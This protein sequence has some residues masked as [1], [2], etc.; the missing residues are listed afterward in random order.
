MNDLTSHARGTYQRDILTGRARISGSD[1]G[2]R[3]FRNYNGYR[4]SRGNLISRLRAAGHVVTV[5]ARPSSVTGRSMNVLIV[6]GRAV[7][8]DH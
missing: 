8:R 5:E 6:D 4:V 2:S 7:S 3:G 1:L